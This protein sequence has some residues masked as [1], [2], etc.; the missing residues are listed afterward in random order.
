MEIKCIRI[1]Q[2]TIDQDFTN[3]VAALTL[4][5]NGDDHILLFSVVKRVEL[6]N[7]LCK[8]RAGFHCGILL[9]VENFVALVVLIN[10]PSC[11]HLILMASCCHNLEFNTACSI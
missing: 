11:T 4:F 6:S 1:D 2:E 7:V 10:S 9:V 8:T 3:D 5:M